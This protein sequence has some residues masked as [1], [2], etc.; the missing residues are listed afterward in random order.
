M[1]NSDVKRITI[2]KLQFLDL[3][4]NGGGGDPHPSDGLP[5]FVEDMDQDGIWID[6]SGGIS[7]VADDQ[8][9]VTIGKAMIDAKSQIDIHVTPLLARNSKAHRIISSPSVVIDRL[10]MVIDAGVTTTGQ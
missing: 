1:M 5:L 2:T 3:S 4:G 10:E 9:E 6:V 8:T 7:L